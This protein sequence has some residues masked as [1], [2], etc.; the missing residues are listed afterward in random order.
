MPISTAKKTVIQIK[1]QRIPLRPAS[2]AIGE[3]VF[4]ITKIA[5]MSSII[6]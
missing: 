1:V 6:S 3:I 4:G 5:K 2:L